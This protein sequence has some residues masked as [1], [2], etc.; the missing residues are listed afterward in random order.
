MVVTSGEVELAAGRRGV[1]CGKVDVVC[2]AWPLLVV[3]STQGSLVSDVS[4][5]ERRNGK[6][7]VGRRLGLLGYSRDPGLVACAA[8]LAT[9]RGVS[10][11]SMQHN[12]QSQRRLV[13]LLLLAR[14]ALCRLDALAVLLEGD[15]DEHTKHQVC[16][17]R[18]GDARAGRALLC[19]MRTSEVSG[20]G[21]VAGAQSAGE[22]G[23]GRRDIVSVG[24]RGHRVE[25]GVA[26]APP[27]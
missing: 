17:C 21:V 13:L 22:E 15:P 20:T 14:F 24:W 26:N 4:T 16:H 18:G 10:Q 19:G 8:E 9:M 2:I 12:V 1:S 7:T 3:N 27:K 6:E 11:V 5:V 25:R 23:C